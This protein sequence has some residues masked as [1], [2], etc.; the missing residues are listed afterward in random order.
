[1][2]DGGFTLIE[3][4]ISI[5][6]IS[7]ISGV[8]FFNFPRLNQDVLLNRAARELTLALREAQSRAVAVSPLESGKFPSNYGISIQKNNAELVLFS[9]GADGS[10]ENTKYDASGQPEE[11]SGECV[12][13]FTFTHGI[14]PSQL[15]FAGVPCSTNPCTMNVLFYR[16]DP[17]MS[18][19]D[20]S[21]CVSGDCG[22]SGVFGPFSIEVSQP[23]SAE[24]SNKR[25]IEVWLTGQ[26]SIR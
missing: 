24:G 3:M 8:V 13:K 18:V 6:I 15:I 2:R 16:P 19:S 1:M 11:C 23:N 9:D 14:L 20:D 21:G 12:K 22:G 7:L 25:I 5:S 4:L 10:V 17:R 26:I